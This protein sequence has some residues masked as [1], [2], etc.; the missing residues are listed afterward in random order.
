MLLL[1]L[2]LFQELSGSALSS[3]SLPLPSTAP[4]GIVST[5]ACGEGRTAAIITENPRDCQIAKL[6]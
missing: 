3:L 4:A 5:E 6:K 2:L 1:L